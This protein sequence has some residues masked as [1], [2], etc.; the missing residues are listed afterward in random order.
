MTRDLIPSKLFQ[1]ERPDIRK[2]YFGGKK[3]EARSPFNPC[4]VMG[5]ATVCGRGRSRRPILPQ[6]FRSYWGFRSCTLLIPVRG[7]VIKF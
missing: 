4:F 5:P 6:H 3:S 2:D 7:I 1:I